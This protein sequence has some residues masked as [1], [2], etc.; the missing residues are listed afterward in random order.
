MRMSTTMTSGNSSGGP[1][2]PWWP[3]IERG[4]WVVGIVAFVALIIQ[5]AF[6][7]SFPT[8]LLLIAL[9]FG[10]IAG[11][12]IGFPRMIRKNSV[13]ATVSSL[14]LIFVSFFVGKLLPLS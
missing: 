12:L 13:L 6:G 8:S 11:W 9:V 5:A 3:W 10:L 14:A 7:L 1:G 4:S 2:S